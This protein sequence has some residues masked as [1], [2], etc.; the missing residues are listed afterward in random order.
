MKEL[1]IGMMVFFF[2]VVPVAMIWA[3]AKSTRRIRENMARLAA[4]LGLRLDPPEQPKGWLAPPQR[5]LGHVRGKA[6]LIHTYSTG[7]GKSRRT[8]TALTVTPNLKGDLTFSLSREGFGTRVLQLF[9]AKEITVGN[10]EFDEAWF[11]QTNDPDFLRAALLP[12][13]QQKF[14]PFR[15]TFKLENSAISYVEEGVIQNDERR[16]RYVQAADLVCDLADVAEVHARHD[17]KG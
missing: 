13:V 17:D 4:D 7:S 5:A 6:V 2:A 12:E 3:V 9:G 14:R 8:W 15:G 1:S 16:L 11:V 10:R